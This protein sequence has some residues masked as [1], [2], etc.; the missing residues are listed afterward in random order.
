LAGTF[1]S[2]N[3]GVCPAGSALSLVLDFGYGSGLYP[4]GGLRQSFFFE[5]AR[6]YPKIDCDSN[7]IHYHWYVDYYDSQC[8]LSKQQHQQRQ[9]KQQQQ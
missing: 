8:I 7:N 4:I 6:D 3:G 5:T 9:Q 2:S 1:N